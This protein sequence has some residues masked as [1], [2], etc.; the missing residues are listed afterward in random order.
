MFKV[1]IYGATEDQPSANTEHKTKTDAMLLALAAVTHM[2]HGFAQVWHNGKLIA[3]VNHNPYKKRQ[4]QIVFYGTVLTEDSYN[5][6]RETLKRDI[7]V[8]V[9]KLNLPV[10]GK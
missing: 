8:N 2:K 5:K 3:E 1:E 9:M 6:V 7:Q 4:C 10:K